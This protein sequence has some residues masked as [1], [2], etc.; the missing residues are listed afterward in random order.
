MKNIL[1]F[2]NSYILIT[3]LLEILIFH[4]ETHPAKGATSSDVNLGP[5]SGMTKKIAFTAE[6]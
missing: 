2:F 3:L 6:V 1:L 5:S 4:T